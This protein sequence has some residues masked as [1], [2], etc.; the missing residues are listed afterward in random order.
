MEILQRY[1]VYNSHAASYTWKYDGKNLDIDKTLEVSTVS[2]YHMRY[3]C[4]RVLNRQ[5]VHFR[6]MG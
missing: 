5:N 2:G 6:R 1:L 4:L 3:G